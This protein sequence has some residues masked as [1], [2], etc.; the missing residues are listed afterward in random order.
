MYSESGGEAD[1]GAA[2]HGQSDRFDHRVEQRGPSSPALCQSWYLLDECCCITDVV[3]AEESADHQ[4]ED[5]R[6]RAYRRVCGT[7]PIARVHAPRRSAALRASPFVALWVGCDPNC[8]IDQV[9][10]VD[11]DVVQVR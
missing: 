6:I 11:D 5:D 10:G 8:G 2:G 9:N 4:I 3:V 1:T 7:A